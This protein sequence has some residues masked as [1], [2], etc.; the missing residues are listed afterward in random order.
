MHCPF[1]FRQTE[2]LQPNVVRSTAVA[3]GPVSFRLHLISDSR[4]LLQFADAAGTPE[5]PPDESVTDCCINRGQLA[6]NIRKDD[7]REERGTWTLKPPE[8][9][10]TGNQ[11]HLLRGIGTQNHVLTGKGD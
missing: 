4:L 11:S 9:R 7:Q 1:P 3:C 10:G 6:P 5:C 8:K 2:E